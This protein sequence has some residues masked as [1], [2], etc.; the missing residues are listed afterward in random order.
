MC[1]KAFCHNRVMFTGRFTTLWQRSPHNSAF[2][3]SQNSLQG[4][5]YPTM[6]DKLNSLMSFLQDVVENDQRIK[7]ASEGFVL[8]PTAGQK[9]SKCKVQHMGKGVT[10]AAGLVNFN[11]KIINCIFV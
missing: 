11:S 4:S 10:I 5:I 6:E 2:K 8:K 7:L 1:S 9:E 3:S